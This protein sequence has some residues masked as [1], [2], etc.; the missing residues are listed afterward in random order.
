MHLLSVKQARSI[1]LINAVDLNPRGLNLFGLINPIVAKYNFKVYPTKL[2]ELVGKEV[3][4]IK[5]DGGGF[6]KDPQNNIAIT[7]TIFNDG[8]VV[9]TRS[10]TRDS[11]A[12]LDDFLNYLSNEFGLSPYQ[13]VLR[14][15][16]YVSELWVKT[17]KYLNALN[18][19]LANFSKRL[20]SL[21]EGHSYH[22]IAYE[23]SG[24]IFWTDP[25]VTN[26][27]TPFRLE[28][29]IDRPFAE[30]RYYSVAPLQTDIHLEMLNELEKILGK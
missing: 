9:D 8:F 1:W 25:I 13:D 24:I 17:E 30:N 28:R 12:F 14:S 21:I 20:T 18:P 10:S 19:K 11:D 26:P 15:K 3:I 16:I 4:E 29:M 22:P 7:L 6:Q 27:P 23:T 5:F 2:E